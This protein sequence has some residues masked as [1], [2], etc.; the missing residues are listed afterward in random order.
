[1]AQGFDRLLRITPKEAGLTRNIP[2]GTAGEDAAIQVEASDEVLMARIAAGDE[3]AFS[4]LVTRHADRFLGLAQ[5]MLGN[6]DE[7]QDALQD[8]FSRLWLKASQFDPKA[9]RFTTWFYRVV[10]NG[11]LDRLRKPRPLALAEDWDT[12]DD[13]ASAD[14]IMEKRQHGDA[15]RAALKTLPERQRLAL[16]LCYFDELSNQ[17]AAEIM[18]I[19]I[20]ALESILVRGRRALRSHFMKGRH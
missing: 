7:A 5:R 10:T 2:T 9:A 3:Q 20:K 14:E 15:V 16:S 1:M 12:A 4:Q 18:K 6:R 13:S 11:C 8:A 19:S 17:E